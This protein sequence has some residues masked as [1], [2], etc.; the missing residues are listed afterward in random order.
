MIVKNEELNLPKCVE[1]FRK[2]GLNPDFYLTDIGSTDS[3][4][5]VAK[6]LGCSIVQSKQI[7]IKRF[8]EA[9]NES[10]SNVIGDYKWLMTIDADD[11]FLECRKEK[12][13]LDVLYEITGS[14][15]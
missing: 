1:S 3:T 9:R 6:N 15:S 7:P 11:E 12:G 10:L 14:K 5:E 2:H 4:F 13:K 8:H